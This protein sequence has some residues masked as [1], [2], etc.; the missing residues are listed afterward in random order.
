LQDSAV[1]ILFGLVLAMS[2]YK[3]IELVTTGHKFDQTL[4]RVRFAQDATDSRSLLMHYDTVSRSGRFYLVVFW[5]L[6]CFY[7]RIVQTLLLIIFFVLVGSQCLVTHL[8]NPNG[9][10]TLRSL[11]LAGCTLIMSIV[12]ALLNLVIEK[13][14]LLLDAGKLKPN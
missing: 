11:V 4:I 14:R 3:S 8:A 9:A 5:Y 2:A 7:V 10:G 6:S 1:S 12:G 13:I